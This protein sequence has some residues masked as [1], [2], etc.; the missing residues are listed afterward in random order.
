M[1]K[2]AE[3]DATTTALMVMGKEKA[4][5]YLAE[6]LPEKQFVFI[7]YNGEDDSYTV[8]TNMNDSSLFGIVSGMATEKI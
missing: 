2:E 4:L 8:Y 1:R 5:A 3:G 7:Y 6:K